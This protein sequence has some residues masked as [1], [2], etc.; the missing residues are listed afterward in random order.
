[1]IMLILNYKSMILREMGKYVII[2]RGWGLRTHKIL[3]KV[4]S[5][6]S[7][8]LDIPQGNLVAHIKM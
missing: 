5:I 6:A 4:H 3:L 2:S 1:M 8:P 7:F